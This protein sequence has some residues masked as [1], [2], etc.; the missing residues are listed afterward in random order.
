ML[1][2]QVMLVSR[3]TECRDQ[4]CLVSLSG[5][6]SGKSL[7]FELANNSACLCELGD[8]VGVAGALCGS[9]LE[10]GR[11]AQFKSRAEQRRHTSAVDV[12]VGLHRSSRYTMYRPWATPQTAPAAPDKNFI[13]LGLD[14]G[15]YACSA[16]VSIVLTMLH[17]CGQLGAFVGIKT[18]HQRSVAQLTSIPSSVAGPAPAT[19]A[20]RSSWSA[21]CFACACGIAACL[22]LR[23]HPAG[24]MERASQ[25]ARC[26]VVQGQTP[27]GA[28]PR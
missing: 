25:A 20:G 22:G 24:A 8:V 27:A 11:S 9:S 7:H 28:A 23:V 2:K 10:P 15:M 4:W 12:A 3:T 17:L 16:S 5:G 21:A 19:R 6:R 13:L 14:H 26:H 18:L 1:N